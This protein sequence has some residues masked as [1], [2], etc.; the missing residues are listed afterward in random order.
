[1]KKE[2]EVGPFVQVKPKK[3]NKKREKKNKEYG[4]V[5]EVGSFA[6]AVIKV[7]WYKKLKRAIFGGYG[8]YV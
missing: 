8:Y 5:G 1:M 6:L 7:P 3:A 4:A 2:F